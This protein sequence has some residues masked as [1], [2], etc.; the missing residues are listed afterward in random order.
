MSNFTRDQIV[1][2]DH[3]WD[4]RQDLIDAILLHTCDMREAAEALI[5]LSGWDVSAFIMAVLADEKGMLDG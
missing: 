1:L 2:Q 3:A 4:N 5:R